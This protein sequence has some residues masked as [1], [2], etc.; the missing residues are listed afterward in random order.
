MPDQEINQVRNTHLENR[1]RRKK[2][3][4][5]DE[6]WGFIEDYSR[7]WVFPN[8]QKHWSTNISRHLRYG[9]G[10]FAS[11]RNRS[12]SVTISSIVSV[13]SALEE[14][15]PRTSPPMSPGN[16]FVAAERRLTSGEA[17]V[18]C[19]QL[20]LIDQISL[21]RKAKHEGKSLN[22]YVRGILLKETR[23][24]MFS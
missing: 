23:E 24:E 22:E 5:E 10:W 19:I 4:L 9:N 16:A 14:L 13:C 17:N 7:V 3:L 2:T 8:A 1:N 11:L 18:F 20:P 12:T 6:L 15:R 21:S